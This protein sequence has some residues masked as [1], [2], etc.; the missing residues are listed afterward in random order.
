[1]NLI[2][3]IAADV[4]T[5]SDEDLPDDARALV[6]SV[7]AASKIHEARPR[8]SHHFLGD[9]SVQKDSNKAIVP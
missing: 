5:R 7:W 2:D 8:K 9:W 4:L 6:Y 3:Q 1:M